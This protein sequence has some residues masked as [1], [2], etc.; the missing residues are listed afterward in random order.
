M[1]RSLNKQFE[2]Y[3]S[4]QVTCSLSSIK[5]FWNKVEKLPASNNTWP[6]KQKRRRYNFYIKYLINSMKTL[7]WTSPISLFSCSVRYTLGSVKIVVWESK[8]T[9]KRVEKSGTPWWIIKT[10]ETPCDFCARPIFSPLNRTPYLIAHSLI[11][12]D[13]L[14]Q[15]PPSNGLNATLGR[16]RA[17]KN[18]DRKIK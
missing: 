6:H 14:L 7:N 16:A 18:T 5:Y 11:Q 1:L 13:P 8:K 3:C 10:R 2:K 15:N 12:L 4:S 17:H 9:S